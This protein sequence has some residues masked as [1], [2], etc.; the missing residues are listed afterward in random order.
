MKNIVI[1]ATGGTIA[2]VSSSITDT[3]NYQ[4][5]ILPIEVIIQDIIEPLRGIAH[6][7]SEQIAQIDS[8]EMTH[9]I[10]FR[11]AGLSPN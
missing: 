5:A 1:L 9:E 2:G 6:I 7:S 11:L 3:A 4:P 10:W 8:A